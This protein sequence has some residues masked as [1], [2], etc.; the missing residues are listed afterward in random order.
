MSSQPQFLDLMETLSQFDSKILEVTKVVESSYQVFEEL[1][2]EWNLAAFELRENLAKSSS[3][4]KKDFDF[5]VQGVFDF[6]EKRE[7]EIRDKLYQYL[8]NQ[9]EFS[10][11]L[12]KLLI[13]VEQHKEN[14]DIEGV[15]NEANIFLKLKEEF[16]TKEKTFKESLEEFK[17]EQKFIAQTL[18][19]F[20]KNQNITSKGFKDT[21][22]TLL[23]SLTSE[24]KIP[25]EKKDEKKESLVFVKAA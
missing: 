25:D 8:D 17:K 24:E 18:H 5:L 9:K 10:Q 7:K 21:I 13:Q 4:R 11:S 6:Q 2:K 16:E 14:K 23:K 12:K 19:N 15:Q 20:L 22:T 3:L 1:K